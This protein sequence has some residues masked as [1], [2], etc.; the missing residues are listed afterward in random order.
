MHVKPMLLS[1]VA[2]LA[3]GLL[4]TAALPATALADE[5]PDTQNMLVIGI[6]DSTNNCVSSTDTESL[7]WYNINTLPN[8][9]VP[10]W[11][12]ASLESGAVLIRANGYYTTVYPDGNVPSCSGGT[13]FINVDTA[14]Q[15]YI[16]G[17]WSKLS[18]LSPVDPDT[19]ATISEGNGAL[20][21]FSYGSCVQDETQTLA[22]AGDSWQTILT[23]IYQNGTGGCGNPTWSSVS[24]PTN[25]SVY[26]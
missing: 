10:S 16:S 8:E 25:D 12:T 19:D 17:S 13:V 18:S 20:Q 6:W 1:L 5:S 24:F 2:T 3:A 9:W 11:D 21:W 26:S 22:Q 23:D 4:L 7:K 14:Q 15:D